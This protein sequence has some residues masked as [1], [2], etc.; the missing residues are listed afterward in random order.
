MDTYMYTYLHRDSM[1]WNAIIPYNTLQFNIIYPCL[2]LCIMYFKYNLIRP[3]I[4]SKH[5]YLSIYIYIANLALVMHSVCIVTSFSSHVIT[6]T[7]RTL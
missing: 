1:E 4:A 5:G 2:E 6:H 3:S 7:C